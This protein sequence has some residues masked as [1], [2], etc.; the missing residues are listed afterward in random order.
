MGGKKTS[1]TG[2]R[3]YFGIHMGIGRGPVDAIHEIKVGDRTA[4]SGAVYNNRSIKIDAYNLFG[5]EEKEGGVQGTLEV[6]MGGDDQVAS[7]GLQAMLGSVLPGFRR[8]ITAFYNGLVSM[9]NPYPKAW[10]FRLGRTLAGWDG[11]V[12]APNLAR[13]PIGETQGQDHNGFQL[14]GEPFALP[15]FSYPVGPLY[16]GVSGEPPVHYFYRTHLGEV[17]KESAFGIVNTPARTGVRYVEFL[18]PQ[19]I[20][21]P[22]EGATQPPI[23]IPYRFSFGFYAIEDG[24][25]YN[26]LLG[27]E[28]YTLVTGNAP[29]VDRHRD[30][31]WLLTN[32]IRR[33]GPGVYPVFHA[34]TIVSGVETIDAEMD[35]DT[36]I[37][38]V[39]VGLLANYETNTYSVLLNGVVKWT[40]GVNSALK[41]APVFFDEYVYGYTLTPTQAPV[42]LFTQPAHWVTTQDASV[43]PFYIPATGP[44]NSYS[45]NGAHIIY[46]CL[47][48]REWG[49]GLDRSKLDEDSFV[50]AANTLASESFGLCIKWTRQDSIDSFVQGILDHIGANLYQSRVTGLM[51]LKLIRSDYGSPESLPLFDTDSGLTEIRESTVGSVGRSVNTITV[52]WHDPF[53]DEDRTVTVKNPAA[54]M[55]ANGVI[56]SASKGYP[57]LPTADLALRVAQR[58]LRA[59]STNL[60]RFTLVANRNLDICHPGDVIA[61]KDEARGIPLM[62]VRIGKVKDGTLRDGSITMEVIQDVFSLPVTAMAAEVPSTWTPP[63]TTPCFDDQAVMEAP[64]FMLARTMSSADLAYM[65]ADG[66]YLLAMGAKGK[67]LNAGVQMAVRDGAPTIDDNPVNENYFCG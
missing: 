48:N 67:P 4:W 65:K 62:A 1:V 13:I 17:I 26:L 55:S 31:F 20:T 27:S 28:P 3:Y 14:Y 63:D 29:G 6:M 21:P 37:A 10:K 38:P 9:N 46:E 64:Y 57:G 41:L 47:T 61:I 35:F 39:L 50:A 30:G 43:E 34:G 25:P 5:G 42:Q 49:R 36:T 59:A 58:D 12:F 22:Q 33:P 52:T 66:G 51:T 53:T 19:I 45:M 44:Q 8:R 60:R 40:F 23:D 56:N 11:P 24:K 7:P 2:Y 15:N 16:D 18:I 32:N 54:I